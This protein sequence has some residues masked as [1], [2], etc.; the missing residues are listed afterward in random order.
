MRFVPLGSLTSIDLQFLKVYRNRY[1]SHASL[2]Q[3]C[4]AS[5]VRE[6]FYVI[7]SHHALVEDTC[8]DEKLIELHILLGEGPDQIVIMQTG[9]SQHRLAV[10]LGIVQPIEEMDAAGSRCGKTHTKSARVFRIGARH[11]RG[12]FLVT[13]LYKPD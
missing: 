1:M 13:H 12:R 5:L 2:R 9:E 4:A 10:E 3:R 11:Q 7:G 8:I 6:V